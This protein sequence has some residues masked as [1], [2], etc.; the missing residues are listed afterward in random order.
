MGQYVGKSSDGM[1]RVT[2]RGR[3]V[4]GQVVAGQVVAAAALVGLT[5]C[6]GVAHGASAR[7]GGTAAASRPAAKAVPGAVAA[8]DPALL[9]GVGARLR[10]QVPASAL[11]A[12]AVYG[13]GVDAP[14]S[15]LVL[16][17]RAAAGKPWQRVGGWATH[18][19]GSGWSLHH[20]VGDR[21]TPVGVF[22]LTDAGGLGP[23]PGTRLPYD[24]SADFHGPSTWPP[25]YTHDF[26][27][28][29]AIDYNRVAGSSPLDP[30]RP[31][32]EALGGGIWLH[33][34]HGSG[35][36]ACVTQPR[37]D[38]LELMRF[39]DPR[40]HPVVVMGDRAD[41]AAS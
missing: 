30:R 8:A 26:D 3:T 1:G 19:G 25:A 20:R 31:L 13:D 27:L 41:L 17:R 2:V 36:S 18:N 24:R 32:G 11:Q 14:T 37:A 6:A 5:G 38:M 16:Y 34:D 22:R 7:P 39:L 35:T 23:N 29:V 12:V 9:P 4:V 28:V 15:T 10:A 40:Q 33:L 21:R